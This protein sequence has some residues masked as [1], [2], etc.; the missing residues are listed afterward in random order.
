MRCRGDV[1]AL[2]GGD[3]FVLLSLNRFASTFSRCT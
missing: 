1:V 3:E 2:I